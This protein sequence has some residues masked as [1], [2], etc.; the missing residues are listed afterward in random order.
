MH[1]Q[2]DIVLQTPSVARPVP[3]LSNRMDIASVFDGQK[4]HTNS[5]WLSV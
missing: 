1:A 2:C 3:A 4:I 5:V